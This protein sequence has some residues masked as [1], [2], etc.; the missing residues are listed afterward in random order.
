[1]ATLEKDSMNYLRGKEKG[2]PEE[3]RKGVINPTQEGR[4]KCSE[5]LQRSNIA[6]HGV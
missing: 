5:K 1:M 2:F 3:W 6:L 4:H